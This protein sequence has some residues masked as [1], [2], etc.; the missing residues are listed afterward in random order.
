MVVGP[1]LP[2][3]AKVPIEAGKVHQ[4]NGPIA[5]LPGNHI[6]VTGDYIGGKGELAQAL[7]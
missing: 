7:N 3:V 2:I 5:G 1:I 4:A 6:M